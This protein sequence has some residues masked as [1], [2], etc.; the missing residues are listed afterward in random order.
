M[1]VP[2]EARSGNTAQGAARK[3]RFF[4]E[5]MFFLLLEA[6]SRNRMGGYYLFSCV[7]LLSKLGLRL[8]CL[9]KGFK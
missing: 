8:R 2:A 1:L 7:F 3:G 4:T 9:K 5:K 6:K